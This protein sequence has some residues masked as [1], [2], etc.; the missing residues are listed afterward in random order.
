MTTFEEPEANERFVRLT[1]EG[2]RQAVKPELAERILSVL[3]K[4]YDESARKREI[5]S[6]LA[7]SFRLIRKQ[8]SEEKDKEPRMINCAQRLPELDIEITCPTSETLRVADLIRF[9]HEKRRPTEIAECKI[10]WHSNPTFRYESL[11]YR[12]DLQAFVFSEVVMQILHPL[13]DGEQCLAKMTFA[14]GHSFVFFGK[15]ENPFLTAVTREA[16]NAFLEGGEEAFFQSLK[17]LLIIKAE[18]KLGATAIRQGDIWA[19]KVSDDWNADLE[20]NL[21][22][23]FNYRIHRKSENRERYSLYNTNH[24]F[25]GQLASA[26]KIEKAH[27]RTKIGKK[28]GQRG[29]IEYERLTQFYI[30]T[31]TI[32]APD[33][34]EKI[35]DDGAYLICRTRNIIP[36]DQAIYG[37]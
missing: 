21:N 11:W 16:F 3:Y 20:T 22:K 6:Q 32:T 27:K 17:P 8:T 12:K 15:D 34:A 26:E 31:G 29:L 36:E 33:H 1:I 5:P 19:V 23:L 14:N 25:R 24:L 2:I 13:K 18:E 37:D 28:S 9:P 35:L 7:K 10:I 30:G 4:T